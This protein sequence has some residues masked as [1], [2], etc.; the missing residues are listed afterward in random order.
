MIVGVVGG[1]AGMVRTGRARL[2]AAHPNLGLD[3]VTASATTAPTNPRPTTAI[4]APYGSSHGSIR[5]QKS[6]CRR[7]S[8]D[9]SSSTLTTLVMNPSS[10]VTS[11]PGCGLRGRSSIQY[12]AH[13]GRPSGRSRGSVSS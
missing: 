12:E 6:Q 10:F 1:I 7:L 2:L 13:A 8:D 9:S 5:I 3:L 4:H 11:S